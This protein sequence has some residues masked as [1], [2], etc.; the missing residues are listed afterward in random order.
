MANFNIYMCGVG[1]QGIGV[2]SEVMIQACLAAGHPVKGVD[3]HGLAQRGGIVS[4]HL[5]LGANVHTPRVTAGEAD[6]VIA[7]E[8]LEAFRA[9]VNVARTGGTVV[10]YDTE[11]QPIHV[12]MGKAEYPSLAELEQAAKKRQLRLERV[13][14]DALPDPRMQNTAVL[15]RLAGLNVI[16]GVTGAHL[17]QALTQVIKPAQLEANLAVFNA[18]AQ[19]TA[20]G[21]SN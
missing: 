14:A 19:P 17:E 2:L 18:Q 16:P 12:R 11:F 9:L 7:L 4:S 21:E 15:G 13:S 20:A 5:R 3:T 8:R 1:G 6:L 10:F